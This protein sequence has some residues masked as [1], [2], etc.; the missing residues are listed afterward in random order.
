M[1]NSLKILEIGDLKYKLIIVLTTL[2]LLVSPIMIFASPSGSLADGGFESW[3]G[4]TLL[5]WK[6]LTDGTTLTKVTG[7]NGFC[8]EIEGPTNEGAE[9]RTSLGTVIQGQT[10]NFTYYIYGNDTM[11]NVWIYIHWHIGNSESS[12]EFMGGGQPVLS[13]WTKMTSSEK[14][15]PAGINNAT[16]RL[17]INWGARKAPRAGYLVQIDDVAASG[18]G[19]T[20]EFS[21]QAFVMGSSSIVLAIG[22]IIKK[23]TRGSK[24]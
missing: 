14:T 19:I 16:I 18:T 15:V 13:Q 23:K 5:S 3:S 17:N 21:S 6:F 20:P 9:L 10:L 12:F 8:P 2:M 24:P 11:I 1:L 7:R 4:N 22:I